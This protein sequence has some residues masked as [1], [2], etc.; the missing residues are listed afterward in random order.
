MSAIR[1]KADSK[2]T[3][4]DHL[5]ET[6]IDCATASKL[7]GTTR[8]TPPFGL[9]M[10]AIRK[11]AIDEMTGTTSIKSA[12]PSKADIDRCPLHVRAQETGR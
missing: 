11:N 5:D 4:R 10:S 9:S 7:Y 2:R 12:L 8:I 3:W 6:F 1:P